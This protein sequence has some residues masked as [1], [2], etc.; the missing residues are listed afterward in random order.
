[1]GKPLARKSVLWHIR[2]FTLEKPYQ[3]NECGEA[4]TT[5]APHPASPESTVAKTLWQIWRC[6]K[7]FICFSF[8]QASDF[9]LEGK[10]RKL[11]KHSARKNCLERK[12]ENSPRRESL[13][14]DQCGRTFR[15]SD[16][17]HQ[18]THS[19]KPMNV[20]NMENS[21]WSSDLVWLIT[22]F[23]VEKNLVCAWM[24]EIF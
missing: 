10:L 4:F 17:W 8:S 1:M 6:R 2:K 7:A 15:D 23:M 3:C 12:A 18:V 5:F 14:I 24:W 16:L 9:I 13:S 21:V 22:E 19:G 20:R 11:G